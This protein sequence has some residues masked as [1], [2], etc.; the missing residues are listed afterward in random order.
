M[1]PGT[2]TKLGFPYK[3]DT[4]WRYVEVT[5]DGNRFRY[6]YLRPMVIVGQKIEIGDHLGMVQDLRTRYPGITPH[7]HFEII[8]PHGE[9][10][11]P[12]EMFEEIS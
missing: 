4:T 7:Y 6:F 2:V 8:N 5:L 10:V 9:Y 11:N 3:D 12:K 1:T